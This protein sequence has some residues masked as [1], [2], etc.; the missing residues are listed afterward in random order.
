MIPGGLIGEPYVQLS[1][2]HGNFPSLRKS[3]MYN[4]PM[5]PFFS[6]DRRSTNQNQSRRLVLY[7]DGFVVYGSISTISPIQI[8]PGFVLLLW[9]FRQSPMAAT[10]LAVAYRVATSRW[11]FGQL[12]S[13]KT[14]AVKF[15]T[16]LKCVDSAVVGLNRCPYSVLTAFEATISLL[17]LT[18]S[19]LHLMLPAIGAVDGVG[20]NSF[21]QV[22]QQPPLYQ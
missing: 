1:R 19:V 3:L 10:V 21:F 20:V 7:G 16:S 11:S 5:R 13:V 18:E 9:N 4:F 22:Y 15:W 2:V 12:I 8:L 6:H 14:F 17:G